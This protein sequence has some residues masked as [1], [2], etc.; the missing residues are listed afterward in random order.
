MVTFKAV[1]SAVCIALVSVESV[2]ANVEQVQPK[3]EN[4]EKLKERSLISFGDYAA[5]WGNS[6]TGLG[7]PYPVSGGAAPTNA[8]YGNNNPGSGNI[9]SY[10]PPP[11]YVPPVAPPTAKPYTPPPYPPPTHRPT[12]RPTPRPTRAP[13]NPPPVH[14]PSVAPPTFKPYTFPPY[15]QPTPRVSIAF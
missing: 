4:E 14:M 9:P 1:L 2:V 11:V 10:T 13:Y 8:P 5:F 6:P 15:S 7:S 3:N 12:P